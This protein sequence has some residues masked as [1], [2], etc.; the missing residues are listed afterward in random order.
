M[1]IRSAHDATCTPPPSVDL[2]E[3]SIAEI[4]EFLG[5]PWTFAEEHRYL[6]IHRL[7]HVQAYLLA[8][9]TPR[10]MGKTRV[11]RT[12]MGAW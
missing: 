10:G 8:A 4:D 1:S 2:T 3:E 11:M 12:T 6:D 7:H 9:R 5:R